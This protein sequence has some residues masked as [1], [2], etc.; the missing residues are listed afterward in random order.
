LIPP[1]FAI[2]VEVNIIYF[3]PEKT[4]PT[5]VHW[6][7]LRGQ[8]MGLINSSL[9]NTML[10]TSTLLGRSPRAPI[11]GTLMHSVPHFCPILILQRDFIVLPKSVVLYSRKIYTA[12]I[13]G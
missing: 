3:A 13:K 2:S 11:S 1:I 12:T 9:N 8:I 10:K 5:T 4:I 6:H 7:S